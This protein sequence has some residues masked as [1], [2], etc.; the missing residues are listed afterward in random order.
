MTKYD[1][2]GEINSFCSFVHE[3]A[4]WL[5]SKGKV[6]KAVDVLRKIAKTNKKEV[7]DEVFKNFEASA[8]QI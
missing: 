6:D 8:K 1:V 7:P 4:R 2:F 3:S 5:I